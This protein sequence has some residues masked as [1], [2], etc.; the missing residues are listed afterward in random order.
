MLKREGIAALVAATAV[1]AGPMGAVPA[2]A[3]AEP[4]P[5]EIFAPPYDRVCKLVDQGVQTVIDVYC[6]VFPEPP[7]CW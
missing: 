2:R 5:C 6:I 7:Y 1:V 4:I 3:S